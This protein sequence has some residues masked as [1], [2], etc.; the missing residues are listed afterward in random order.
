VSIGQSYFSHL[1]L[2]FVIAC[3]WL[4]VT[5]VLTTKTIDK[6][7][8]DFDESLTRKTNFRVFKKKK[9]LL[10]LWSLF[11]PEKSYIL[12]GLPCYPTRKKRNKLIDVI[13]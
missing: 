11:L 13:E 12:L 7:L 5:R 9:K 4:D 1:Y 10:Q 3:Q 2:L 6:L 8:L